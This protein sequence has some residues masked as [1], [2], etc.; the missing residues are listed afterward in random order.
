MTSVFH[1]QLKEWIFYLSGIGLPPQLMEPTNINARIGQCSSVIISFENP[2]SENVVVDV[3]LTGTGIWIF[4]GWGE[5][6][7]LF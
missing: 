1:L 3:M 5:E 7:K 2:T 6:L 4:M